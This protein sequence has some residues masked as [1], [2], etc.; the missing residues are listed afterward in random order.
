MQTCAQISPAVGQVECD[1]APYAAPEADV[2]DGAE[3]DVQ[4]GDDTHSQVQHFAEV[5]RFL[6][7]VF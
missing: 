4:H 7:F 2:A 6:H 3:G 5:L 1:A